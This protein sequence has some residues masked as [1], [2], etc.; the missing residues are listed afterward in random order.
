[1]PI[2]EETSGTSPEPI[3]ENNSFTNSSWGR[4][5]GIS[6]GFS[7]GFVLDTPF[8]DTSGTS[9]EAIF[10][11]GTGSGPFLYNSTSGTS[12]EEIYEEN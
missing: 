4:S 8:L 11:T 6:W 7:W 3:Y 12:P 5:W 10:G 2:Y 1:M 9:P